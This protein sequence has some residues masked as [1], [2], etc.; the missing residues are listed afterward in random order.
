V[1]AIA[2]R[3]GFTRFHLVG[4]DWGSV[5]GWKTVMEHP[6]QIQTWTS[7]SI[8]HIGIFFK[9]VL[10]D[11]IQKKRSSYFKLLQTP[12]T[13]E[14]YFLSNE[15]AGLKKLLANIPKIHRNEYLSVFEEPGA[16]TA[17]LNW[18]RSLDIE[19]LVANKTLEKDVTVP[20]L[21]I[22]GTEDETIAPNIIPSQKY[23]IKAYYKELHL[24]A[25]HALIQHQEKAVIDALLA[26]I[27]IE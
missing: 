26:H 13:P 20:T 9:A 21:F 24:K 4:H 15:Q 8:P 23:Y 18:Y 10:N 25:G 22:W 19:Q 16:L 6:S 1:L 12:E 17:V 5:V 11:S 7:L 2:S 27:K 3:I 14:K